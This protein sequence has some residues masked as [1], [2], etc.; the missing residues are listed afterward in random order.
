[1]EKQTKLSRISQAK[2]H[3]SAFGCRGIKLYLKDEV[4][5]INEEESHFSERQR[6]EQNPTSWFCSL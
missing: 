4:E 2:Q 1:M 3:T 5:E 6:G